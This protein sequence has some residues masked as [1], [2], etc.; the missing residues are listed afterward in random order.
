MLLLAIIATRWFYFSQ[1]AASE[2][3][4]GSRPKRNRKEVNYAE[5]NDVYLPPLG[6]KDIVGR[7]VTSHRSTG[8]RSKRNTDYY[9]QEDYLAPRVRN[10]SR[11]LRGHPLALETVEMEK[12]QD[13]L[14]KE[15]DQRSQDPLLL[16][17]KD[18][19]NDTH[20][21]DGVL[22]LGKHQLDIRDSSDSGSDV[23]V[24]GGNAHDSDGGDESEGSLRVDACSPSFN[25]SCSS[26]SRESRDTEGAKMDVEMPSCVLPAS[27]ELD[28]W[29]TPNLAVMA[30]GPLPLEEGMGGNFYQPHIKSGVGVTSQGSTQPTDSGVA[31][32]N[33]TSLRDCGAVRQ[34]SATE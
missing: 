32:Q 4:G 34:N 17:D 3:G 16:S 19:H 15:L 23:E 33:S 25:S 11:R 27:L 5:L 8:T 21:S 22:I 30:R 20:Q 24:Y 18:G 31:S 26:E 9:I 28:Q 6:P 14:S 12:G 13:E 7:D 10:T 29:C 2:E 1:D